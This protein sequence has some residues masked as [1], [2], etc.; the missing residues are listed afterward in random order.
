MPVVMRNSCIT[1]DKNGFLFMF[2]AGKGFPSR[3]MFS[4]PEFNPHSRLDSFFTVV[5]Q[6]A[7]VELEVGGLEKDKGSY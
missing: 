4:R 3:L 5:D 1:K 2:V 6:T 7:S